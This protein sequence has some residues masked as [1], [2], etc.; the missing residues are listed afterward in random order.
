MNALI[1]VGLSFLREDFPNNPSADECNE[2]EEKN[3]YFNRANEV[4]IRL[5]DSRNYW[6]AERY[7]AAMLQGIGRYEKLSGKR[8]NKGIVYANL[9]ISQIA[10]GKIDIG[11]A[12]LL[13]AEEEDRDITKGD[14]DVL[15]SSLWIPFERKA[16]NLFFTRAGNYHQVQFQINSKDIVEN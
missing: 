16:A 9:G 10:N 6:E 14:F 3:W 4:G 5:I 7:F 13:T 11:I 2:Y 15:T 8:F 12:N 1:Q